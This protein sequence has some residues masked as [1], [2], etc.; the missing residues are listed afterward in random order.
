ME[1]NTFIKTHRLLCLSTLGLALVGYLGY[2]GVKWL[3]QKC[4]RT[5]KIE[6]VAKKVFSG[7]PTQIPKSLINRINQVE[8]VPGKITSGQGEYI[9]FRQMP[10][11]EK[12]SLSQESYEQIYSLL[13][14]Y[15]PAAI[16]NRSPEKAAEEC[17]KRYE[18]LKA[19]LKTV[20]PHLELTFIPR[21]LYELIFL[22]KCIKEDLKTKQVCSYSDPSIQQIDLDFFEN[23]LTQYEAYLKKR[24]AKQK[25]KKCWHLC[26]F[27]DAGDNHHVGV[28]NVAYRLNQTILKKLSPTQEGFTYQELVAHTDREIK[29]LRDYL[30]SPKEIKGRTGPAINF[31]NERAE[32]FMGISSDQDEQ[33]I[34][35]AVKLECSKIAQKAFLLYR[36]ADFDK[37]FV[38]CWDNANK[39]YSISY[40]SSLFAGNIFDPGATA[41]YFMRKQ[42]NA[43]AIPVPFE[44]LHQ[45]PFYIPPT[46][47]IPQLFGKG[48][49]FHGRTKVWKDHDSKDIGGMNLGGHGNQR[50]HLSSS[51]SKEDFIAQFQ[52]A[53]NQAIQLK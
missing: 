47:T 23:D 28:K 5:E 13:I 46:H 16:I 38:S 40:G 21:T 44:K 36:G 9:V 29:F 17:E 1:I 24:K 43:Y 12:E 45:S 7:N 39:P 53:K 33:M 3:I 42:K 51:L 49:I 32:H 31:G 48:E 8:I 14:Q 25:E 11:G 41:F 10:N 2:R 37:D 19:Q 30:K 27:T 34:R 15:S 35:D 4:F 20:D 18:I 52:E 6:E 50:E 26:F 22:R